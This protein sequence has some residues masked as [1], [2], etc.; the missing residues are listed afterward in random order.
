MYCIRCGKD[1]EEGAK[2]CSNCGFKVADMVVCDEP[3]ETEKETT[4]N[5]RYTYLTP[6]PAIVEPEKPKQIEN[7]GSS[8]PTDFFNKV[9]KI[10]IAVAIIALIVVVAFSAGQSPGND[11]S[12]EKTTDPTPIY[13]V[14]YEVKVIQGNHIKSVS[15]GGKYDGGNATLTAIP[16]DGYC[17]W[18]WYDTSGNIVSTDTTYVIKAQNI[19]LKAVAGEGTRI[20]ILKGPGIDTVDGEGYYK[21]SAPKVKATVFKGEKFKGWYDVGS[22]T[23]ISKSLSATLSVSGTRILV[24]LT[25]STDYKG[26]EILEYTPSTKLTDTI[27]IVTDHWTGRYVDSARNVEKLSLNVDPGRYDIEVSGFSN[28]KLKSETKTVLVDGQFQKEYNWKYN[29]KNYGMVWTYTYSVIDDLHRKNIDRSPDGDAAQKKF[30]DYTSSTIV[31]MSKFLAEKSQNM[32]SADRANFVLAFVQQITVYEL[33]EDYNGKSDYFKYPVE[34]L[35]DRRGDC[36][37][38]SILYCAL[39]KGMGY[40]VALCR[41]TS[42]EYEG[43]GHMAAAVWISEGIPGGTYYNMSGKEFYYC[44]TTSDTMRVGDDW[45]E[46]DTGHIMI[47]A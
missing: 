41:Y 47:I 6:E 26:S 3:V 22:G 14:S 9:G 31:E 30:V 45:D 23:I 39:M 21:S 12:P 25:E 29:G 13:K 28:G 10:T 11:P 38:T 15:G 42:E 7:R 20:T 18:G 40:D 16:E 1:L 37:D 2:F 4:D 35:Y 36:E 44:E 5:S 8:K 33:D 46:Y 32:S 17:F 19:T 27:W 24:A 43:R 34:T